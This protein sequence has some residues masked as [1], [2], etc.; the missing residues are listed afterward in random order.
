MKIVSN[1]LETIDGI[2]NWYVL[3]LLIFFILFVTITIRVLRRPKSEMDEIGK[4]VLDDDQ[5]QMK[6]VRD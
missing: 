2:G 1:L 6:S 4:S 5:D 3:G